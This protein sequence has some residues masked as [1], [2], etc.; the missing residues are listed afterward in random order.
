MSTPTPDA[1][2]ATPAAISP[3]NPLKR[4]YT[5]PEARE[6]TT[7]SRAL[8][9]KLEASGHI[10]LVRFGSKT[11]VPIEAIDA[12]L[13]GKLDRKRTATALSIGT[14]RTH[15]SRGGGNTQARDSV[16]DRSGIGRRY[17]VGKEPRRDVPSRV[18][19][20]VLRARP[21]GAQAALARQ[22]ARAFQERARRAV[23]NAKFAGAIAGSVNA[24][25]AISSRSPIVA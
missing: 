11:L 7:F 13:T 6:V 2:V 8:F 21:E 22:T 20:R 12:T 3:L 19:R 16:S 25:A 4:L 9:Y 14:A 1:S 5:F 17:A 10:R 18:F 23:W 24:H 15:R